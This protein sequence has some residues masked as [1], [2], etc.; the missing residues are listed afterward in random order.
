MQNQ[1][2]QGDMQY[3]WNL[4]NHKIRNN[5]N[6][7]TG[8]LQGYTNTSLQLTFTTHYSQPT[9]SGEWGEVVKYGRRHGNVTLVFTK[10]AHTPSQCTITGNK[11][12]R[13]YP[14]YLFVKYWMF[15][16]KEKKIQVLNFQNAYKVTTRSRIN[17]IQ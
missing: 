13:C 9:T 1:D 14:S 8:R 2:L 16:L 17:S 12:A 5:N 4:H 3:Q 15:F 10:H 11:P 6:F 7:E